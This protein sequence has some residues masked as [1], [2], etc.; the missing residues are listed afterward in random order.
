MAVKQNV[1]TG[2]WIICMLPYSPH[3]VGSLIGW[4]IPD[5]APW[6]VGGEGGGCFKF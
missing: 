2:L 1:N 3:N 4:K 5:S 6:A